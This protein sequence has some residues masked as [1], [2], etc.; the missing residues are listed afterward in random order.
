[1][2][3]LGLEK[4]VSTVSLPLDVFALAEIESD[5][6]AELLQLRRENASL[7]ASLAAADGLLKQYC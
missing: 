3:W 5:S 2:S 6:N 7:R 1:M 4:N